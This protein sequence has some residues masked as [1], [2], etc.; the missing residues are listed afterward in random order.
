MK[1]TGRWSILFFA[2]LLLGFSSCK[3]INQLLTFTVNDTS[4]VTIDAN[5]LPITLPFEIWTP[6]IT[7]NSDEEFQNNNT[8]SSLV[9][10]VYITHLYL[11]IKS[12]S[13]KTFSF[14]KSMA[15]YI[16]TNDDDEIE[17]AHKDNISSDAKEIQLTVTSARLDTYIKADSYKLR[18]EVTTR[19]T[20]TEKV[21]IG[22]DMSFKVTADPL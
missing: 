1:A 22:I 18:T 17:L 14:L 9:K 10:D 7:T 20:L 8:K 6:P 13:D 19:E 2:L 16:S 11:K 15:I 12:P 5:P 3:K 21:T 4:E